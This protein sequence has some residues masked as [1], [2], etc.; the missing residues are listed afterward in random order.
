MIFLIL[1]W[2][3]QKQ[4]QKPQFSVLMRNAYINNQNAP[5]KVSTHTSHNP[6]HPSRTDRRQ[7]EATSRPRQTFSTRRPEE[8]IVS[9]QPKP[10]TAGNRALYFF[11][12]DG[13]TLHWGFPLGALVLAA[14]FHRIRLALGTI[15]LRSNGF[16]GESL[17]S[18]N[19]WQIFH[20][21]KNQNTAQSMLCFFFSLT[22][23]RSVRFGVLL[24]DGFC[25]NASR[26]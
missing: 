24:D 1:P 4:K 22:F 10:L 14:N 25:T 21:I 18:G 8:T 13:I 17:D 23:L 20:R 19:Y 11:F 15:K 2:K 9:T 16:R 12:F 3:R 7:G 6:S 26:C 5:L